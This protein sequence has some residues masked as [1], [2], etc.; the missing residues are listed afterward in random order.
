MHAQL[1]ELEDN[2]ESSSIIEWSLGKN[3]WRPTANGMPRNKSF[4]IGKM[5]W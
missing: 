3:N 5:C 1:K 2:D 4:V